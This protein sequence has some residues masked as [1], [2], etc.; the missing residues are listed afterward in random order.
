MDGLNQLL[1]RVPVWSVYLLGLLPAPGLFFL[2][3][4]GGLGVEPVKALEHEYGELALK[5]LVA[6]LAVTPLRRYAGLNLMRFRRALGVLSF[7]YVLC[8]LLVWLLLDVQIP[9]QILADILK[10]P[11][12]TIGMA[13]FV[14]LLP[15]AV[16]SNNAS[17]RRLGPR[18]R[19][20][21]RLTYPAI[22]L[23][24]LHYVMLVKGFQIEPLAYLAVILTLLALRLP[25]I[26]RKATT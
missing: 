11:Y 9:S 17:V 15:L 10:R 25:V 21:H 6:V 13:A 16:T 5:L 12:I 20:L 22:A 23:G 7:I 19:I 26:R 2:G 8:H 14:L 24:A 18:W 4:T 3:L 1:R